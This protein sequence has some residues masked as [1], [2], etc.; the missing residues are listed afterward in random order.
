MG[1]ANNHLMLNSSNTD[2]L[3][4]S[5]KIGCEM[6]TVWSSANN[7]STVLDCNLTTVTLVN[8]ITLSALINSHLS[9]GI[10]P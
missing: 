2:N 7:T 5:K 4:N 6:F 10:L 3:H 8:H 1:I 9:Y